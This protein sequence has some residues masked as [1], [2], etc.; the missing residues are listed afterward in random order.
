MPPESKNLFAD[1]FDAPSLNLDNWFPYYLPHWSSKEAAKARYRIE[2]SYLRLSIEPDQQPWCP[3]FDGNVR[4]SNLQ[5]GHWA[6]P[7]GSGAG[8]HRFRPDL[9]VREALPEKRLFLPCHCRLEMRARA[10]LNPWNL[11]ALWL[12]GF[13]DQPERSGEITVFEVFGKNVSAAGVKIG[14]GIKKINDPKLSDEIDEGML[15][16]DVS[17]WHVYAMHWTP[18]GIDFLIDGHVVTSTRQSPD[19]PMQ[20]MLNFYDLPTDHD[21]AYAINGAFDIDYIRAWDAT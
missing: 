8:Q 3:E 15:P 5:T 9:T 14:R 21:R 10:R 1:E 12:I 17:D 4:V 11:A 18:A 13:E 16:I 2:D 19:Y 7:K 20:L 6:G